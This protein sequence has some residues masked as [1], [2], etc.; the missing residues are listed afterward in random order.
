[1]V[2]YLVTAD[3]NDDSIPLHDK[4]QPLTPN[5]WYPLV[6]GIS[7]DDARSGLKKKGG[8]GEYQAVV[9]NRYQI[10]LLWFLWLYGL[11][12]RYIHLKT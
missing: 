10:G 5:L 1:M 4:H 8:S 7:K 11:I 12:H 9:A 3:S 6:P 2:G